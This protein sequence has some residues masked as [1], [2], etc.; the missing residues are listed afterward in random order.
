MKT[1]MAT[2]LQKIYDSE[3]HI[4][5]GWLWD[6]GFDYAIGSY[7]NDLWDPKFNRIPLV[8]TGETDITVAIKAM[9]DDI[10]KEYPNSTF[11]EWWNQPTV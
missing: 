1:D 11:A 2:I 4:R 6:G 5:F 8:H 10:A 3:I 9:A 7:S